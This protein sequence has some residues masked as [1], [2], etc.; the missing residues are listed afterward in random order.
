[1][2]ARDGRTRKICSENA[3]FNFKEMTKLFKNRSTEQ[4]FIELQNGINI[5]YDESNN[6]LSIH[7]F[8]E[9]KFFKEKQEKDQLFPENYNFTLD[10]GK[11]NEFLIEV[12]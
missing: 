11:E 10:Q 2:R 7:I 12:K 4:I 1:M 5:E 6:K 9:E 8:F 3:V